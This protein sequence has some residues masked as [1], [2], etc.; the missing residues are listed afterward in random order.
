V[1]AARRSLFAWLREFGPDTADGSLLEFAFRCGDPVLRQGIYALD[2][3][4]F[5]D[6]G[7][8][9]SAG[10][11]GRTWSGREFWSQFEAWRRSWLTRRR[12]QE[13]SLTDLY[14]PANRAP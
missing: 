3:E 13:P 4:G 12:E 2:S 9:D 1:A 11:A 5:R 8:L 7:A 6:T 10:S 14:A